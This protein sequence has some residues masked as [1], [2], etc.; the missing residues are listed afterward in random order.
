[1]GENENELLHIHD[2]GARTAQPTTPMTDEERTKRRANAAHTSKTVKIV[3]HRQYVDPETGELED[4]QVV[5]VE[6][7]DFNFHKIWLKSILYT[8]DLI[9]NKKTKLAF[10][11][12]DNLD[13]QNRFIMTQRKISEATGMST[14]TINRTIKALVK[15]DFLIQEQSGVYTVNPN[16][17]FKG[18]RSNR[19]NVLFHYTKRKEEKTEKKT[20]AEKEAE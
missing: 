5:S 10:W 3:G 16:V 9:G 18:T 19:L 17:I 11:I 13:T 7:R 8:L 20:E 6:D 2:A 1:M 15:S 12:V 4:F 14:Q